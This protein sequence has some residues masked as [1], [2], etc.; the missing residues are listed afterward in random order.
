MEQ[1]ATLSKRRSFSDLKARDARARRRAMIRLGNETDRNIIV[2]KAGEGR[3][4]DLQNDST[5]NRY[6]SIE[7]KVEKLSERHSERQR[8]P[9]Q[10]EVLNDVQRHSSL[11]ARLYRNQQEETNNG[12]QRNAFHRVCSNTCCENS[13]KVVL[14][15]V[16]PISLR[17]SSRDSTYGRFGGVILQNLSSGSEAESNL[18]EENAGSSR[19][20]PF[21]P[22]RINVSPNLR[23][24]GPSIRNFNDES[25]L[26]SRRSPIVDSSRNECLGNVASSRTDF[27]K[28]KLQ[29]G[30]NDRSAFASSSAGGILCDRSFYK[31]LE[32]SRSDCGQCA[33]KETTD[34]GP[35]FF[36][37]GRKIR[38][39]NVRRECLRPFAFETLS[40][41]TDVS[42]N[43]PNSS[44]WNSCGKIFNQNDQVRHAYT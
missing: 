10:F 3:A 38:D 22:Q 2:S 4:S 44:E 32:S 40:T 34:E 26:S 42:K 5:A 6:S 14:Q 7:S 33:K 43:L 36:S 39:H 1:E 9:L 12:S 25:S 29:Q 19:P 15:S 17:N 16:S 41:P 27:S 21:A 18:N 30:S 13:P 31:I 8:S 11:S 24:N 20:T 23:V 37:A 35:M 28:N